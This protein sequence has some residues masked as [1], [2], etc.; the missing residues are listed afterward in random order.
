MVTPSVFCFIFT[1]ICK[2]PTVHNVSSRFVPLPSYSLSLPLHPSDLD[3]HENSTPPILSREVIDVFT[4]LWTYFIS[5]SVRLCSLPHKTRLLCHARFRDSSLVRTSMSPI[6]P[7]V[8]LRLKTLGP[9]SSIP[10]S[11]PPPSHRLLYPT[12]LI[13]W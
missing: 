3:Y 4:R 8:I 7:P 1:H 12:I 5:C 6:V 13:Q 11:V 9:L 2:F 10:T